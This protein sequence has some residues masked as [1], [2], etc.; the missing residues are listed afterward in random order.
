MAEGVE[1]LDQANFLLDRGC[2]KAQ[3]F[4]YGRPMS[5]GVFRAFYREQLA[6]VT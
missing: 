3:G 5:P 2:H 6:R 4:L 1:H